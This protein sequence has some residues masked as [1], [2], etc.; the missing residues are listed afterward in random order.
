MN[1]DDEVVSLFAAGPVV[2]AGTVF[3]VYVFRQ[4]YKRWWR[5]K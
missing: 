2:V 4:V 1:A 3:M 5:N